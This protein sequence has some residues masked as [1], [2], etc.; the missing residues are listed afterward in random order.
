MEDYNKEFKYNINHKV[1]ILKTLTCIV[2]YNC[3]TTKTIMNRNRN[4]TVKGL[5]CY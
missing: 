2:R 3:T 4:I 5:G 1:D